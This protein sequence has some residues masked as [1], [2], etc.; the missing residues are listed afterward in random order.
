MHLHHHHH[1]ELHRQRAAELYREAALMRIVQH[2]PRR[3]GAIRE[4]R[5][6]GAVARRVWALRGVPN[7]IA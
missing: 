4:T 2:A 7:I 1:E 3:R 6:Y 5:A